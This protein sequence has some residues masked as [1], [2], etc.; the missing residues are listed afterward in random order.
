MRSPLKRWWMVSVIV[1][2]AVGG[3]CGGRRTAAPVRTQYPQLPAVPTLTD[4]TTP[5]DVGRIAI[6]ALDME[7]MK[8]L[9]QLAAV[10]SESGAAQ[11]M[12]RRYGRAGTPPSPEQIGPMVA[13]GW[14]TVYAEF[15]RGA[16]EIT[17]AV[18]APFPT[19]GTETATVVAAGVNAKTKQPM[20]LTM[21]LVREDG[22]W[23]V[24]AGMESSEIETAR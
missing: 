9:A 16:T 21:H 23:K 4:K 14:R 5:D 10:R 13:G 24:R 2:A 18:V 6:R 8:T 12:S 15:K 7:D 3:G 1:L 11:V 19:Q 22:M 20:T 17:S